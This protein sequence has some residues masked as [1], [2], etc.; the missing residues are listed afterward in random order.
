MTF[1]HKSSLSRHRRIHQKVTQ[2]GYCNRTF[3]YE[4]F[5]KKHI[6]TAH[7]GFDVEEGMNVKFEPEVI[8]VIQDVST[9]IV[10]KVH[11]EAQFIEV[12]PSSQFYS[13]TVTINCIEE[14][15]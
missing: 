12:D 10:S 11:P 14:Q 4:S 9:G 3:R 5:L 15:V 2:C 7:K 13:Q 1:R 8:T 6:L